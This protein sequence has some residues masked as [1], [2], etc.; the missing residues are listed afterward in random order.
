MGLSSDKQNIL[1]LTGPADNLTM[2]NLGITAG[3]PSGVLYMTALLNM[4]IPERNGA[5][6][7]LAKSVER[8][9][10]VEELST[11]YN[12]KKVTL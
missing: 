3:D 2:V 8:I 4:V 9:H 11:G 7:W 10:T 12:G 5:L 6:P 1:E